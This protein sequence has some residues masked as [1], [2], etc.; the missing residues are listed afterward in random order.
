MTST[1]NRGRV[2][3]MLLTALAAAAWLSV[4]SAAENLKTGGPY[5]PTPQVVVDQMLRFANVNEKDFVIDLGSG[6]GVIIL[7]A[8]KKLNA[9]GMGVD[10]GADL[11]GS[12]TLPHR[13]SA[14]RIA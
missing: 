3:P 12:P 6:D 1:E 14:L 5:V 11:S 2:L 10:F 9:S 8:A 13:S 4:A 7:T